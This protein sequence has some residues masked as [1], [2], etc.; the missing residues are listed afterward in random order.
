MVGGG[1]TGAILALGQPPVAVPG[2]FE[3]ALAGFVEA[4]GGAAE[5]VVF[6]FAGL[7][8]GVGDLRHPPSRVDGVGGAVAAGVGFALR[9]AGLGPGPGG[10]LVERVG[11]AEFPALGVVGGFPDLAAGVGD[12]D[13]LADQVVSGLS[14]LAFGVGEPGRVALGVVFELGGGVGDGDALAVRQ[15]DAAALPRDGGHEAKGVEGVVGDALFGEAEGFGGSG[16]VALAVV[17]VAGLDAEFVGFFEEAVVGGGVAGAGTAA[18]RVGDLYDVVEFIEGADGD[19]A[20]GV[21]VAAAAVGAVDGERALGLA[22]HVGADEF[23]VVVV[24]AFFDLGAG[25]GGRVGDAVVELAFGLVVV[26]DVAGGGAVGFPDAGDPAGGAVGEA[27]GTAFGVGGGFHPLA[28][29]GVGGGVAQGVGDAHELGVAPLVLDAALG[30]IVAGN[31]GGV[32]ADFGETL[33][34]PGVG[35]DG[36]AEVVADL[37]DLAG[38]G[39][40]TVFDPDAEV[41]LV[42]V[43]NDEAVLV[44]VDPFAAA[45]EPAVTGLVGNREAAGHRAGWRG[46]VEGGG[47]AAL[48]CAGGEDADGLFADDGAG[49]E[50]PGVALAVVGGGV[51]FDALH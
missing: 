17:F 19:P 5:R 51:A 14:G 4:G 50:Y 15:G 11:P 41:V 8:Q 6:L 43:G 16:A 18:V 13:R 25:G 7:V 28:F 45:F 20:F 42:A 24:P 2:E 49:V 34:A 22:V 44:V 21:G 1:I 39:A 37:F 31:Q 40:G 46:T 10:G 12:F 29:P 23:A 38:V 9:V 35:E 30:G 26:V 36:A 47:G 27:A 48:P 3:Q 32:V 33:A